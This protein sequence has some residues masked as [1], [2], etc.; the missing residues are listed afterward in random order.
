MEQ[1][2]LDLVAPETGE[3]FVLAGPVYTDSGAVLPGGVQV[4]EAFFR[5]WISRRAE[6]ATRVLAMILPQAICGDEALSSFLV[7][8]DEVEQ[9]TGWNFLPELPELQQ[10]ELEAQVHPEG[11]GM[12]TVD[13]RPALFADRFA[14]SSCRKN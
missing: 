13:R 1:A 3:L 12:A 7:S 8:I 5:I 9:R 2:E 11:W 4:P 6:Q 10:Q 14:R